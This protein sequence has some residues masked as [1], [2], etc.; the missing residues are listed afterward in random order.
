MSE[1]TLSLSRRVPADGAGQRLD[2]WLGGWEEIGSRSRATKLLDAKRVRV[3]GE[4]ARASLAVAE[5]D[6]VEV[7]LPPPEP[8]GLEPYDIDLEIVHEDADLLVVNKP[9]GLVVH[10][11]AG[12]A[13]DTLVNAL[14]AHTDDLSM[15]FAEER[16]GIVHRIDKETSGLLVVAKNNDAQEKLAA[17]FQDRSIHRVYQAVVFGELKTPQ[18]LVQSYLARH[19]VD[20]KRFASLLGLD[21]K[22]RREREPEPSQGKW[23]VTGYRLLK[24][25]QGL[26]FVELKLQTGRTHQIRVHLSEMGHPLVGD[27]LYGADRK[28][29]SLESPKRRARLAGLNRF[30][31]HAR[32]LGFVH[33]RTG[34]AMKFERPWPEDMHSLLRE[35]GFEP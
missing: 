15:G 26:S 25:N 5:N 8:T 34:E 35:W 27:S 24:K 14:I 4:E 19:P 3:N 6:F 29:K 11:A 23:A 9:S 28:L 21:G 2:K 20:R 33:P 32:E 10:P 12:H 22:I 7:E 17:Q 1:K 31:L 16:P 18:G 30:L 13:Q